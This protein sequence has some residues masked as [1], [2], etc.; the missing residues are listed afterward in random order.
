[1]L[2]SKRELKRYRN[3][4]K[5]KLVMERMSRLHDGGTKRQSFGAALL[6]VAVDLKIDFSDLNTW[7]HH[8]SALC[9]VLYDHYEELSKADDA[10]AVERAEWALQRYLEV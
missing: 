10:E 2:I 8:D 5:V 7:A 3:D 9:R 1:M 4:D 6:A